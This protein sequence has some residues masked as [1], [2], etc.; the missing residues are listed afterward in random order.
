MEDSRRPPQHASLRTA[1]AA[2]AAL[3]SS[4]EKGLSGAEALARLRRDGA[5]DVLEEKRHPLLQF[6]HKF[7]GPSAWILELI[8]ALS[9]ALGKFANFWIAVVL[10][11]VNALLSFL[12]EQRASAALAALRSRLRV[13]AR[14]LRGGTWQ[15]I[16][17]REL[18]RGDVVRLR[19]GD[20]VPA[21]LLVIDGSLSI[22]QSALT[23]EAREIKRS[24]DDIVFSGS[25]A[26]QGEAMAVVTGTG[27][28]T[29]FGQTAQLIESAR[30]RL[31]VEEVIARVVKWLVLIVGTLILVTIAVSLT[32]GTGLIEILPLS[33]VLLMSA[34]PVAL[35]VMFTV[36]MAVGSM[37]LAR[38]GVLVT[39][40]SAAE[41]AAT[42]D[43]VCADKTGTLTM[44]RLA[45]AS[46]E[47][48]PGYEADDVI[49]TGALA[50][51]EADQDQIDLAFLHA[52][53][54]RKLLSG[55]EKTLSFVPF[56][57]MRRRTEAIVECEGRRI[58]AV[59]GALRTIA[60]AAGLDASSI[61]ALAAR[62]GEAAG[63]GYRIIA[64][65]RAED[66]MALTVTG[67]AFLYDAPRPDSRLL[68]DELKSLG[69]GVKMLTGDALPVAQELA[70]ELGLGEVVRA[71]DL[72]AAHSAGDMRARDLATGS[73]GFAEVFPEDKFLTVECLQEAGH[74]VGMTGDGVNDAPALRQAEVGIAV[75]GAA[76]VAKGAASVVLT[77]EGLGGIVELVKNGRSIYQRVLTWI[78]NKVSRAILESGFVV[79]AFLVSGKFVISAL[80]MVLLVFMTDFVKIALSTDRVHP[81]QKPE[82][83]KIAPLVTLAVLLGL[84]MLFE[85]LGLLFVGSHIFHLGGD[86]GRLHTFSF[87]TLLFFALF[88][89]VSI[90]ERCE[91]W[92]SWPSRTLGIALFADACAGV[93]VGTFGLGELR[94]LRLPEMG[95]IAGYSL[96][97]SLIV[98]DFVKTAFIARYWTAIRA[99]RA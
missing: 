17:A 57:P 87:E 64:V 92:A 22:D 21:D 68:I 15:I 89:L 75:A 20:F 3:G 74:I 1:A 60:E 24:K 44:N 45:L 27:T 33:L 31:H 70:R 69:V 63:K 43:V 36:S 65:A 49:R 94:P 16:S 46:V 32:E 26:R 48:Q 51:N 40:L 99:A 35:P 76:D 5:N 42:M 19:S 55:A 54:G 29:Y 28:G 85:S 14:V 80:G 96:L 62:A 47:P 61:A 18:V 98:N 73:S 72:R 34:I 9:F 12:Q 88:S 7:W 13:T 23:G 93:A 53:R 95:L 39:R 83:W 38:R 86:R 58:K 81:S 79:I 97:F 77:A 50:S 30:S 90:R 8:A 91:W 10:L 2:L 78:I 82:S 4:A 37:E 11:A 41:D 59:K 66:G 71:P 25:I 67:L 56:S 52:A 6:M 84:L